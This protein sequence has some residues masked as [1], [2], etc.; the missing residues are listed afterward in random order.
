MHEGCQDRLG[1]VSELRR[2]VCETH[3]YRYA[4]KVKSEL[5]V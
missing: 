1:L 3:L 4:I 2:V 5:S